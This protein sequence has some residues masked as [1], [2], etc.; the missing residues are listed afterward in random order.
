[1]L[2]RPHLWHIVS[3]PDNPAL[4]AA[5]GRTSSWVAGHGRKVAAVHALELVGGRAAG[6]QGTGRV[7][8]ARAGARGRKGDKGAGRAAAQG[9][10]RTL[11]REIGSNFF[12][13]EFWWLN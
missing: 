5:V 3:V 8:G 7:G 9:A 6:A 13:Y 2:L 12:L 10:S 4:T 11:E 1:M